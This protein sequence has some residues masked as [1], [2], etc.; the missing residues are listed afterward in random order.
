MDGHGSRLRFDGLGRPVIQDQT[1]IQ[2]ID[3]VLDAV[4]HHLAEP[5]GDGSPIDEASFNDDQGATLDPHQNP[6]T[7]QATFIQD[8]DAAGPVDLRIDDDLRFIVDEEDD[9]PLQD[10]DLRGSETDAAMREHHPAHLTGEIGQMTVEA[11][12]RL[13]ALS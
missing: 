13:T 3:L 6:R 5:I 7:G 11:P 2:V 4:S 12:D 8:G 1:P 9:Q 10:A